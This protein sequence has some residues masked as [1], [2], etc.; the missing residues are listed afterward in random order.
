M[1]GKK[2]DFSQEQEDKY[3]QRGKVMLARAAASG[4]CR[5]GGKL[6]TN[7]P[8]FGFQKRMVLYYVEKLTGFNI[9]S[10]RQRSY[11]RFQ[12][13]KSKKMET[14]FSCPFIIFLPIISKRPV[15]GMSYWYLVRDELVDKA[16]PDLQPHRSH[17]QNCQTHKTRACLGAIYMSW[18]RRR[19]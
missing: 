17:T 3:F 5:K 11:R 6:N 19:V 16:L 15:V 10:N 14:H 7:L 12:K 18:R 13:I 4:P 9:W 1:T 8:Q 2:A